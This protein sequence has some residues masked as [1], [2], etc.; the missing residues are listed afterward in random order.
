MNHDVARQQ[1]IE[2]MAEAMYDEPVIGCDACHAIGSDE[3]CHFWCSACKG[4]GWV[5]DEE[6]VPA[7]RDFAETNAV[8][9]LDALL[10]A[11]QDEVC[12]T[13]GG[14]GRG[15]LPTGR[16]GTL[17]GTQATGHIIVSPPP[18]PDC[19]NGRVSGGPLMILGPKQVGHEAAVGVVADVLLRRFDEVGVNPLDFLGGAGELAG[20]CVDAALAVTACT[21]CGGTGDTVLPDRPWDQQAVRVRCPVCHGS[22]PRRLRWTDEYE[23]V[24]GISFHLPGEA[25]YTTLYRCISEERDSN[26]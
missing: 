1:A 21:T 16:I 7:A 24:E 22:P 25:R 12:G 26:A 17:G 11:R 4:Q 5:V 15:K 2:V 13:C 20:E 10:V 9:A 19:I 3:N 23:Q 8:A 6:N 18:C 14:K